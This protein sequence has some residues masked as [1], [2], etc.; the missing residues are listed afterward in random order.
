MELVFTSANA[1]VT[2][3]QHAIRG[4]VSVLWHRLQALLSFSFRTGAREHEIL[5]G[6]P[7][8]DHDVFLLE[9]SDLVQ[10]V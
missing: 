4:K 2:G 3:R 7:L 9:L 10:G 8:V 1:A 6:H 5:S